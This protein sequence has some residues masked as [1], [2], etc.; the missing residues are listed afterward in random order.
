MTPMDTIAFALREMMKIAATDVVVLFILALPTITF[1]FFA[2]MIHRHSTEV[3]AVR[4]NIV[5][6]AALVIAALAWP[7]LCVWIG[8]WGA[9]PKAMYS[10]ERDGERRIAAL[11]ETSSR[12]GVRCHVF[13][14]S[15]PDGGFVGA[16]S[17]SGS[18]SPLDRGAWIREPKLRA[19]DLFTGTVQTR[20]GD[21]LAKQGPLP[22]SGDWKFVN[23]T[24]ADVTIL[25]QDGSRRIVDAPSTEGVVRIES[26]E[27][28]ITARVPDVY[29]ARLVPSRCGC[30]GDGCGKLIEYTTVMFGEGPRRIALLLD[31]DEPPRLAWTRSVSELLGE[32]AVT[33]ST[34]EVD[35]RCVLVGGRSG[36]RLL[37]AELDLETGA[38]QLR[39]ER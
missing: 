28:P 11:S 27:T 8:A 15:L 33:F 36:G 3:P 12:G 10:I 30:E 9:P 31:A 7:L 4:R 35:G 18:C 1:A 16:D 34:L 26:P 20:V 39:W 23:L 37:L 38:G 29:D 22:G 13:T 25:L 2:W 14:W 24:S 19:L 6:G 17:A 32:D 21:L 5:T